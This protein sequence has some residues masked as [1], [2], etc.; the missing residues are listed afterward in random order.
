MAPAPNTPEQLKQAIGAVQNALNAG[1]K[2]KGY[3]SAIEAACRALNMDHGT[4]R[5][6]IKRALERGYELTIPPEPEAVIPE[7]EP[8]HKP[9]V[10]IKAL[11]GS[12]DPIYKILAVGDAHD[13]PALPD[14][15][16][17]RWIA[18]HAAATR[19]DKVVQIGDFADFD[20]LSRHD[21][22]GSLP[23]KLRP[24]YSHDMESLEE[25]LSAMYKEMAGLDSHVTIGNH[26]GRVLRYERGTAEI[27]GALWDPLMQLFARY[28]WRTHEEGAFFFVG[29]VGFVH[30]PRTLMNREYGGKWA[31][32]TMNDMTFSLVQG[33]SHRGQVQHAPKIGPPPLNGVT[34]V[35]LGTCLP[36]GYIKEY[37]KVAVTGW[38]YGIYELRIQSGRITNH[39]FISMDELKERY[40]D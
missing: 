1:Y 30:A 21:L 24:N 40:G 36:T 35:N 12:D 33:H 38:T 6:R 14:K 15:S 4:L 28:G 29:G 8:I 22:A 16:R 9:R 34:L 37:A 32:T 31:N 7:Y 11:N 13:S 20:S 19:P 18:R 27:E 10:K 39:S 25:A 3:P 23:Q 2:M 5:S 26:E 17:F